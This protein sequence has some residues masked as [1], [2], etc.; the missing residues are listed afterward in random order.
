MNPMR[1]LLFL[2]QQ[3]KLERSYESIK[4]ICKNEAAHGFVKKERA[5]DKGTKARS[6]GIE[7][8]SKRIR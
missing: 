4:D 1:E 8:A 3:K 5:S 2:L 6:M 7:A